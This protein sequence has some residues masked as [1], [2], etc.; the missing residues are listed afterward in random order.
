VDKLV[1]LLADKLW[2]KPHFVKEKK[3]GNNFLMSTCAD[4][5]V[6]RGLDGRIYVLDT[7]RMFPPTGALVDFGK[8]QNLFCLFRK[9]FLDMYRKHLCADSFSG[10][11]IR[12]SAPEMHAEIYA[13]TRHLLDVVSPQVVRQISQFHKASDFSISDCLHSL[14]MNIRF[15]GVIRLEM[16]ATSETDK[17]GS[18]QVSSLLLNE[19]VYRALKQEVRGLFRKVQGH[20]IS[21]NEKVSRCLSEFSNILNLILG[22]IGD[23]TGSRSHE[24][25]WLN[26]IPK[27]VQK[28]FGPCLLEEEQR[29]PISLKVLTDRWLLASRLCDAFSIFPNSLCSVASRLS[30]GT[31]EED[32]KSLK[33]SHEVR[34]EKAKRIR[35]RKQRRIRNSTDT[36][37]AMDP[38]D[39][40]SFVKPILHSDLLPNMFEF[41]SPGR[42]RSLEMINRE[43]GSIFLRKFFCENTMKN[44]MVAFNCLSATFTGNQSSD[45]EIAVMLGICHISLAKASNNSKTMKYHSE[46][47][48]CLL[49]E[50]GK[51]ELDL[52]I[53]RQRIQLILIENSFILSPRE[54]VRNSSSELYRVHQRFG[55]HWR[56]EFENFE[57][58]MDHI[59]SFLYLFGTRLVKDFF[60]LVVSTFFIQSDQ[61]LF[62]FEV[63]GECLKLDQEFV[64]VIFNYF[65]DDQY[66]YG[67]L[68]QIVRF[69]RFK[70]E[71]EL[72][73]LEKILDGLYDPVELGAAS[74]LFREGCKVF[75][76]DHPFLAQEI[77][78][79]VYAEWLGEIPDSFYSRLDQLNI[80]RPTAP[81][82]KE[83][84]Q[85]EEEMEE[86]EEQEEEKEEEKESL[87]NPNLKEYCVLQREDMFL[88][89]ST[90][91]QSSKALMTYGNRSSMKSPGHYNWTL[92]VGMKGCNQCHY[93]LRFKD[94]LI[95]FVVFHLHPAYKNPK[96]VVTKPPFEVSREGSGSFVA[97]I[98]VHLIKKVSETH[99]FIFDYELKLG[100]EEIS[101]FQ[102]EEIVFLWNNDSKVPQG[103]WDYNFY[104]LYLRDQSKLPDQ[105][106]NDDNNEEEE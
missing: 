64:D 33:Y 38:K 37:I 52:I 24:E 39:I 70:N 105:Y 86:E 54:R 60:H 35:F 69:L 22:V 97:K 53:F 50:T 66:S 76:P 31:S 49:Q 11:L 75:F 12:E 102:T 100:D 13:A 19:I 59:Q 15:L 74:Y 42:V 99:A 81:K 20:G 93:P 2:L 89:D 65:E 106:D 62:T 58:E 67:H 101:N 80:P 16:L 9:E 94:N 28:K 82:D 73:G 71:L 8:G 51:I 104:G 25:F 96:V 3:S 41:N 79:F 98:E 36:S 90:I 27:L 56:E 83:E 1:Q 30:Q 88:S 77:S 5:E 26:T 46:L 10:F 85:E 45:S 34:Q 21:E 6:H 103:Y 40:H 91:G 17:R 29:N 47:A 7:A 84:Q 14:G 87:S 4:L 23:S 72:L 32:L 48:K 63:D 43:T 92:S 78:A 18:F 57:S 55:N 68:W 95:Q 44:L 61:D